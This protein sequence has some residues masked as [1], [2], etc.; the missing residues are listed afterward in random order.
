MVD[1]IFLLDESASMYPYAKYYI[2][3]VNT[4]IATQTQENPQSNFTMIKFNSRLETLCFESK[5]STLPEFT[6]EFY[7]PS[8]ITALYDAIG[9]AIKL[10][11]SNNMTNTIVIILTDGEDN[12]SQH[13][14]LETISQQILYM[15]QRGWVF[16]YV[17]ANQ[18]AQIIGERLGI[19][20]CVRYNE[21]EKSISDVVNAC[22]IAIGHAIYNW[23]G[24]PNRYCDQEIPVD[25]SDIMTE[26]ENISI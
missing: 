25:V 9:Y 23:S 14:T 6:S 19:R 10:K 22:N 16:V 4:L 15:Q 1:I 26:M 5:M 13:Y 3:G 7:K 24:I 20:T 18:K 11:H 17:A 8:G 2:R 12:H 21:T